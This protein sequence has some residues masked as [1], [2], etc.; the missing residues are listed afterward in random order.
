MSGIM[1]PQK[2]QDALLE[3]FRKALGPTTT[4]TATLDQ[5]LKGLSETELSTV[6]TIAQMVKMIASMQSGQQQSYQ[7]IVSSSYPLMNAKLKA[8]VVDLL[9]DADPRSVAVPEAKQEAVDVRDA[10]LQSYYA[11]LGEAD[12]EK[13]TPQTQTAS[14]TNA[15][16]PPLQ[17]S[18][19][20]KA[21]GNSAFLDK[22]ILSESSGRSDAEITIADGRRH[23]GKLQMG[24]ARL[25]DYQA[26]TGQKFTQDE[27]KA[28]PAL[29]DEVAQWH[30][31]DIDNAIDALGDAAKGYDR[32][33]LRSVAH[34]G[35]KGGMRKFVKSGGKYNPADELGT[36]LKTYYDKFSSGG[37]A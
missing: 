37:G 1:Q 29:Q 10:L 24:Q 2:K 25:K 26:A 35:G 32:D 28:D 23:V 15:V 20:A 33:G 34:L 14:N 5:R 6:M 16:E 27:F 4:V 31:K 18:L 36:S 11:V 13:A 7:Q 21:Q 17:A 9:Q 8:V 30:F 12:L 3:Q 22:L 19:G